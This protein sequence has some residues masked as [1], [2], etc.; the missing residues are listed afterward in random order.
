M[1]AVISPEILK[2]IE[3][4]ADRVAARFMAD[5]SRS[6]DKLLRLNTVMDATGLSRSAVYRL[7]ENGTLKPVKQGRALSFR[8]TEIDAY[9]ASFSAPKAA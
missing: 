4:T 5:P 7:I 3:A 2:I 1:Q 8:S 9:I 6:S